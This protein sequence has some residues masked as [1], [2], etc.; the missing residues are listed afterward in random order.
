MPLPPGA[1]SSTASATTQSLAEQK[2]KDVASMLKKANPETLTPELQHFV[3]EETK[4]ATKKDAKTLYTAVDELTKAREALDTALLARSNLMAQWRA[5]LMMS[6]E[7]FRQ[8]T[9]HFQQQE[10]AHQ[11][12]IK[13]AKEALQKAKSDFSTKEEEATIISDEDGESREDSTK[14][15]AHKILEG[16]NHMTESLQKLS[17]Q[18]EKE[19][20][21]EEE[22]KAKRPRQKEAEAVDA[23]MKTEGLPSMQP[24]GVPGH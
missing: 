5:F 15:S 6:L 2:L 21:E 14:E 7:R 19:H 20:T 16:L 10:L 24:F 13:A 8:Y 3:A 9:D 18:A 12:N 22:R 1:S 11:G 17:E 4:A 23:P